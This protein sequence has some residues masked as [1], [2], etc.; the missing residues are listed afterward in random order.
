M[1][2]DLKI[3]GVRI[4]WLH[5]SF[6]SSSSP[7]GPTNVGRCAFKRLLRSNSGCTCQASGHGHED[8]G[9]GFHDWQEGTFAI[10]NSCIQDKEQD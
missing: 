5:S 6:N 10:F 2:R 8:R 3:F 1:R 9:Q 7:F 4:F